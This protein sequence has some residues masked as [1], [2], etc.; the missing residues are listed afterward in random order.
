MNIENIRSFVQQYKGFSI[1]VGVEILLLIIVIILSIGRSTNITLNADN[2]V[3]YD[4]KV[5]VDDYKPVDSIMLDANTLV[6]YDNKETNGVEKS[7]YITGRNDGY[8]Y[9][10]WII[11]SGPLNVK[12]GVYE[13]QVM[14]Y[15]L[16]YDNEAGGSSENATASIQIISEKNETNINF[17]DMVLNDSVTVQNSRM[18]IHSLKNI[19]DLE[20]KVNFYG[21]GDLRIDS[22]VLK[23]LPL[24]RLFRILALILT[25]AMLDILYIYIFTDNSYK[26]K[27]IV[28]LLFI[29]SLF[30]CLPVFED[31][32]LKG[33]DMAFHLARIEALAENIKAGQ[34]TFPIQ[35]EMLNGYG[36][37]SPIF[38]G[39]ILFY[40]PALLDVA[41]VPLQVCYQIYVVMVNVAT[42]IISYFSFRGI[43]NDK[44]TAVIGCMLYTLSAYR[45]VNVYL[46][47]A[48][49]EYTAM[50]FFP[51]IIYG[52]V[53]IYSKDVSK[54]E[55]KECLALVIGLTG[56]VQ[57][58]VLSCELVALF[59]IAVCI[60]LFRKTF[61]P[62]R[63][64]SLVITALV[65]ALLNLA[66][67]VP[68]LS[69]MG[70]HIRVYEQETEKIQKYGTYLIQVL[71]VFMTSSGDTVDGMINEMPLSLGFALVVGMG[72]FIWCCINKYKWNINSDR[73][74]KTGVIC[75]GFAIISIILST[76]F[77]PWDSLEQVSPILAKILSVVQFPWIYLAVATIFAVTATIIGVKVAK[78]H[79]SESV[80]R[81][82][83]LILVGFTVVE[84]G[85]FYTNFADSAT[86]YK[87]YGGADVELDT[88]GGEY[89]LTGTIEGYMSWRSVKAD[90]EN[91]EISE[92]ESDHGTITFICNNISID[93]QT[94]EIPIMNY[95]NYHAYAEDGTEF[96]ISN[97]ENNRLGIMIPGGYNGN[98]K[99]Q[100]EVPVLWKASQ[101][102]SVITFV[103]IVAAAVILNRRKKNGL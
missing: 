83:T 28:A 61:E 91:V 50:M 34:L 87:V 53:M 97:G 89:M 102:V 100:Y 10:R 70:M 48:V 75:I 90:L 29:I 94:V 67:L 5:T 96:E 3:I 8:H 88:V 35:T 38:Y 1:A 78:E 59:I 93:S 54:I 24:W 98:V 52:F 95:D 58:H 72:V 31:F 47:S 12:P 39:Q 76:N 4:D 81:M 23:E 55:W 79:V 60:I 84:A 22:I 20:I 65:T 63:F 57:S 71:E 33:H 43:T 14:Y 13:L 32:L 45:I 6:V 56:L 68:F 99:V 19:D 42:V 101:A 25:F 41:G 92:Y 21:L 86:E 18:W 69:S 64:I 36:Y 7:L 9:G 66:F 82:I 30:S 44:K 51:L 49:G 17:N 80:F 27:D 103:M 15:S 26:N 11:G 16:L 77:F 74:L 62:K 73:R 37:A 46:R 2:L 40:M 85:L